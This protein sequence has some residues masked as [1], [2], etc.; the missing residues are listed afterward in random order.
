MAP[1]GH[2]HG[3]V[4]PQGWLSCQNADECRANKNRQAAPVAAG[5]LRVGSSKAVLVRVTAI[6][7]LRGKAKQV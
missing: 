2:T 6:A 7:A 3:D 5:V 1:Q 4:F